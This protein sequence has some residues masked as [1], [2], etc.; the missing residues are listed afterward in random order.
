MINTSRKCN[1]DEIIITNT[2]DKQIFY[3]KINNLVSLHFLEH[4]KFEVLIVIVW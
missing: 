3:D 4:Q 1:I 2:K